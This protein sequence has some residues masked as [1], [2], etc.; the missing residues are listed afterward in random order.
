MVTMNIS[1]KRFYIYQTSIF[2]NPKNVYDID[3]FKKTLKEA[4]AKNIRVCNA[5]GWYN[6]PQIVTFSI[7]HFSDLN[8]AIR[9]I[10]FALNKLPVFSQWGSTILEKDW[11]GKQ[12]IS[13]FVAT[14]AK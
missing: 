10:E 2:D 12:K 1:K 14:P 8:K 5:Y 3:L 7:S 4:G 11:H 9:D 13:Q 6:Q